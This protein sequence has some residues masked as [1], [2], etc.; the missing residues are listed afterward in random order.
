MWSC[1]LKAFFTSTM[2]LKTTQSELTVVGL[3][4]LEELRRASELVPL[5]QVSTTPPLRAEPKR[6]QS[7]KQWTDA[8]FIC[9][10]SHVDKSLAL[11]I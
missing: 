5:Q 11:Q 2:T 9:Q 8:V 10:R 4:R 7:L 3:S 6:M 1:D